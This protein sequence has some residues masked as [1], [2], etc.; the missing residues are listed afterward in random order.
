MKKHV[1]VAFSI[2]LGIS[3]MLMNT[4]CKQERV[5]FEE[6]Q[7]IWEQQVMAINAYID[8]MSK[9][10]TAQEMVEKIDNFANEI[11]EMIPRIN[12]L[13]VKFSADQA[14]AGKSESETMAKL[15]AVV[16]FTENLGKMNI[17]KYGKDPEV[18]KAREKLSFTF[19]NIK[20][21]NLSIE[22][23][24][25]KS[26][27]SNLVEGKITGG[28]QLEKLSTK[29]GNASLSSKMK[30][31]MAILL[32]TGRG[33]QSFINDYEYAPDVKKLDELNY[34]KNFV[35]LYMK[36]LSTKDAWG[37]DLYYRAD[38]DNFWLGSAGSDG[39]FEG[40]EQQGHYS[41]LAGRDIILTGT[42][43]IYGPKI[44]QK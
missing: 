20:D 8:G 38:G 43:F 36:Q 15:L 10:G 35:P 22:E 25:I 29:L 12:Q 18:L 39:K 44:V 27:Y 37:N 3:L 6:A 23:E 28:E 11:E 41:D 2:M 31:T 1:V 21:E 42:E 19:T 33:I 30:I 40:F 16:R 5:K 17:K 26:E 7:A 13:L 14:T 9:A 24:S 34:Y 4:A 32:T